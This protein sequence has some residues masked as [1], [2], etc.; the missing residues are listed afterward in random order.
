MGDTTRVDTSAPPPAPPP[1]PGG[2][3]SRPVRSALCYGLGWFTG[4]VFLILERQDRE[5]RFHALHS[6]ILF[7]PLSA[8]TAGCYVLS[9][10]FAGEALLRI[11][12][13]LAGLAFSAGGLALWVFVLVKV[14][15]GDDLRIPVTCDLARK[16]AGEGAV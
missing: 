5:V 7:G 10:L 6:L 14:A 13:L 15:R 4:L 2:T 1:S 11:P 3:I 9:W 8:V 16:F 12:L